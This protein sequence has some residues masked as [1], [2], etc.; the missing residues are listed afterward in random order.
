MDTLFLHG[1]FNEFYFQCKNEVRVG[2]L[3][4]ES[5]EQLY[6]STWIKEKMIENFELRTLSQ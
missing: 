1:F 2:I 6:G 4:D 3:S 5:L